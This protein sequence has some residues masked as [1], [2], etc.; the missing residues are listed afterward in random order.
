MGKDGM[1]ENGWKLVQMDGMACNSWI[2]LKLA[3][4]C[5]IWL[6]WMEMSG[7]GRNDSKWLEMAG[8]GWNS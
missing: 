2:Q 6:K 5:W 7:P 1:V 3:R 8:N 4:N